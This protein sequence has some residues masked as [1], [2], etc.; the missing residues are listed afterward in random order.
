M[1]SVAHVN[2]VAFIAI[3]RLLFGFVSYLREPDGVGVLGG[4]QLR[5]GELQLL[6]QH[7]DLTLQLIGLGFCLILCANRKACQNKITE[8][9]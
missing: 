9:I 4:L 8:T 1:K 6:L 3:T 2:D 7:V 5:L